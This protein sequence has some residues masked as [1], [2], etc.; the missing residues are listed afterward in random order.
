MNPWPLELVALPL[1][2]IFTFPS[3][4]FAFLFPLKLAKLPIFFLFLFL[5]KQ[6]H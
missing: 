1:G 2:E 4:S 6:E 3:S 5:V